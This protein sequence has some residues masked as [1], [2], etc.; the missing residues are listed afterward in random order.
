[1]NDYEEIMSA[2]VKLRDYCRCKKFCDICEFA[3]FCDTNLF[4]THPAPSTWVFE[5]EEII[6][7]E[8]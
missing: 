6:C 7:D 5:D 1:M 2:L 3:E 4:D 8:E